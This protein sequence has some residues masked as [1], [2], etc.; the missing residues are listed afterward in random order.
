MICFICKKNFQDLYTL[1]R[2]FKLFHNLKT[3]DKITCLEG[4]C[5]QSFPNLSS[6]K[7]HVQ[8]KHEIEEKCTV[9]TQIS[10]ISS[11][12]T[13]ESKKNYAIEI[14]PTETVYD[15]ILANPS[16]GSSDNFNVNEH[17]ESIRNTVLN[18]TLSLHNMN[19]FSKKDVFVIQNNVTEFITDSIIGFIQKLLINRIQNFEKNHLDLNEILN[20]LKDPFKLCKTEF[21][22]NSLLTEKGLL[23]NSSKCIIKTGVVPMSR[24]GEFFY[25]TE[26]KTGLILPLRFQFRVAFENIYNLDKWLDFLQDTNNNSLLCCFTQ[27]K[28]WQEK[29]QLYKDKIILPY[30][31]YADD[32]EINNPLGSQSNRQAMTAIYYSFP[33]FGLVLGDN[34]GINSILG[35]TTSFISNYFCRFCKMH[36]KKCQ[37]TNKIDE[38]LLRNKS[39][40][41]I[42]IALNDISQTGI[43]NSCA[44]NKID[45]FHVVTNFSVDVMHDIFEEEVN[46]RKQCFDYGRTEIGNISPEIEKH[47]LHKYHLKM[48]AREMM[49]F[50]HFFPLILGDLV[51]ENHEIWIFLIE[52]IEIIDIILSH[53]IST[54][55]L[56]RLELLVGRHLNMY[57]QLFQDT[58]KPKHHFLLH[59][60]TI[61]KYSGPPRTYWCFIFES[62]HKEFKRYA[63]IINS[64]INIPLTLANKYQ[65]KFAHQINEGL[66]YEDEF[67]FINK[68]ESCYKEFVFNSLQ[69]QNIEFFSQVKYM[70]ILYKKNDYFSKFHESLYLYKIIEFAVT[71]DKEVYVICEETEPDYDLHFCAYE[72]KE[73]S[74]W[75][76]KII[77]FKN[78][79]SGPPIHINKIVNSRK[80]IRLKEYFL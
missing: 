56:K 28:L 40:Y 53:S 64:R 71:L 70:D 12:I 18:F 66:L 76:K 41:E 23:E 3:N 17:L 62:K 7:K 42:D 33:I 59:Y 34:L 10:S 14:C 21:K 73:A 32:F 39:N 15:N 61:I 43:K 27:G 31:L 38:T 22:L 11:Q 75:S 26:T 46:I 54:E 72:L 30:F 13:Q 2:H 24:K 55:Y 77:K 80:F 5:S 8:K 6:F 47:H 60:P 16:S 4:T 63:N 58:L 57:C 79:V 78:Y 45:S 9:I 25:G 68:I 50:V 37:V 48:S 51:P 52:F 36:K 67:V 65:L 20:L 49:C 19:N 74:E 29:L 1:I 35:F 69:H 44:L